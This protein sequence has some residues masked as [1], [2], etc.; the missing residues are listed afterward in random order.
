MMIVYHKI[1]KRLTKRTTTTTPSSL[2]LPTT[3]TT[4]NPATRQ[5]NKMGQKHSQMAPTTKEARHHR[6]SRFHKDESTTT[7][8]CSEAASSTDYSTKLETSSDTST[9]SDPQHVQQQPQQPQQSQLPPGIQEFY[10]KKRRPNATKHG[11]DWQEDPTGATWLHHGRHWPRDYA[12]IRGRVVVV[13]GKKW[14]LATQ[15]KQVHSNH[16]H[17]APKGAAVPFFYGK[18]YCLVP[19]KRYVEKSK[20]P[21]SRQQEPPARPRVVSFR[22]PRGSFGKQK[23]V[24]FAQDS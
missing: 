12:T 10:L 18:S 6:R 3:T 20:V 8:A 24:T 5:D 9:S 22:S 7:L 11:L 1:S 19:Y 21:Q 23:S 17:Q 2:S 4:V 15:V 13:K 14:L 16:W